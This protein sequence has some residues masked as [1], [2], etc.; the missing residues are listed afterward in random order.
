MHTAPPPVPELDE[1]DG[2]DEVEAG[3]EE[4]ADE[5]AD[6]PCKPPARNGEQGR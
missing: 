6:P 3:V 5:A 1:E 4:S 2:A